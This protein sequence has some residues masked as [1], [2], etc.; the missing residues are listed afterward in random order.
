MLMVD[1]QRSFLNLLCGSKPLHSVR[2][3]CSLTCWSTLR[4]EE[5]GGTDRLNRLVIAGESWNGLLIVAQWTR[6]QALTYAEWESIRFADWFEI[7]FVHPL[8]TS[9]TSCVKLCSASCRSLGYR[10]GTQWTNGPLAKCLLTKK[11]F[12]LL[13]NESKKQHAEW[14]R[15]AVFLLLPD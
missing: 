11:H 4:S 7:R 15:L 2:D 10:Q 3:F 6:A 8:M 14:A 12:C 5:H 9:S 13:V 1:P